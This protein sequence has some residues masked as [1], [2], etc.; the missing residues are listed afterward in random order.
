MI[1]ESITLEQVILS[2][3]LGVTLTIG[4]TGMYVLSQL[5][6]FTKEERKKL[7]NTIKRRKEQGRRK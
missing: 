4:I 2:L 3:G 1:E 7:M 6:H 5:R